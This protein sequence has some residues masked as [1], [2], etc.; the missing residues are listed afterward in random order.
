MP[1]TGRSRVAPVLV[2]ALL[3]VAVAVACDAGV[4]PS[5]TSPEGPSAAPTV[6]PVDQLSLPPAAETPAPA[7]VAD[8]GELPLEGP[9]DGI[10][11]PPVDGSA[12]PP[13]EVT[14]EYAGAPRDLAGFIAEYRDEFGPIDASD[15][16]IATAG[17]R[18]C[19]YLQRHATTDGSVDIERAMNEADINEP[20]YLRLTWLVAFRVAVTH[21][22]GGFSYSPPAY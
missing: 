16:V 15:D 21:Y 8:P 3:A 9:P 17:A 14:V 13:P 10:P 5:A 4:R 2:A 18:L 19:T 7:P 12:P 6:L 1:R 22:C 11:P 20:G